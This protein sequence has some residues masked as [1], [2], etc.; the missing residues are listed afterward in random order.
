MEKD[1]TRGRREGNLTNVDGSV[2][3]D[4]V[5]NKGIR[6]GL[7]CVVTQ[8]VRGA[9]IVTGVT[10][11]LKWSLPVAAS[12]SLLLLTGEHNKGRLQK[13][14]GLN[15]WEGSK[16]S[17]CVAPVQLCCAISSLALEQVGLMIHGDMQ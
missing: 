9:K 13:Q 8:G 7:T 3:G 16:I 4:F 1:E 12:T 6:F 10:T 15:C 17:Y 11:T 2:L 14:W 5:M